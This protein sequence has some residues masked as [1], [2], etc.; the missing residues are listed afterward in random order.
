MD[1]ELESYLY[2]VKWCDA[3]AGL[4]VRKLSWSI[5]RGMG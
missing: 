5:D 3:E 1:L 4:F 2:D